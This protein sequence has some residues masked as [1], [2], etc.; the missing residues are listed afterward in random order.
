M[1]DRRFEMFHQ[2]L[3]LLHLGQRVKTRVPQA[4]SGQMQ[5]VLPAGATPFQLFL[6]RVLK[7]LRQEAELVMP[8]M[9]R[10]TFHASELSI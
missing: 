2:Q 4:I 10:I 6:Q 3:H 9:G 5:A 7:G 8:A 1:K